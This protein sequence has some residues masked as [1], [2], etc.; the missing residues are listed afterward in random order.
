VA[1]ELRHMAIVLIVFLVVTGYGAFLYYIAQHYWR[2]FKK[3]DPLK[4]FTYSISDLW[5]A[6]FSLTPTL[7]V[8][9]LGIEDASRHKYPSSSAVGWTALS[10]LMLTAQG[11]GIFIGRICS[12]LPGWEGNNKTLASAARVFVFGLL[13]LLLPVG[14]YLFICAVAMLFG[15][16][17]M[18]L[19]E[20][21]MLGLAIAVLLAFSWYV[22]R[23]NSMNDNQR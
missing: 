22:I 20:V 3:D 2:L 1:G 5:G 10:L 9:A 21:P 7:A 13:G 19:F 18:V 8:I 4:T 15:V 14:F 6:T 23:R 17:A 11:M 16:V 12:M